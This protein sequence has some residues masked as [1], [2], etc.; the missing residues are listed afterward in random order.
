MGQK[1]NEEETDNE[2]KNKKHEPN[3]KLQS[4]EFTK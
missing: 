4:W 2:G 3:K 1:R